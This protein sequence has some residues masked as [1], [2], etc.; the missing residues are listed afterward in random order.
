M[1]SRKRGQSTLE[2]ALII[3]VVVAALLAIN[4][5]MRKSVSGRLKQSSD[6]IGKPFDPEGTFTNAWQSAGAETTTTIETRATATGAT[7]SQITVGE[8]ITR[9][10]HDT[11]GI[12]PAQH[13]GQ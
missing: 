4:V 6:D 9:G 1:F 10:E 3:G 12:A 13:Y 5:Y 8:T 7:T 2:Y 11:W